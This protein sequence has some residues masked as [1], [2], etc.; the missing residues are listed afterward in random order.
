MSTRFNVADENAI[1]TRV[2][3]WLA[4]CHSLMN[5]FQPY[6]DPQGKYHRN[7]K[8]PYLAFATKMYGMPYEILWANKE[9]LNGKEAKSDT[10]RK[11]QVAKPAVLG[12]IYRM[13][14]GGWGNG[15]ASYIDE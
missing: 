5:V 1:E 2:G 12:S 6:T 10:K 3:G 14:G 13:G 7:G 8:D 4:E 11:R 15:K 9:G